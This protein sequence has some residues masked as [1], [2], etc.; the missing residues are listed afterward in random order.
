MQLRQVGIYTIGP[1][2]KPVYTLNID[3][4]VQD[5]SISSSL[6]M[7]VLQSCTKWSILS[8]WLDDV[9]SPN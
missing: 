4:L 5:C 7:E 1:V 8:V 3:G 6:A 2:M 9:H